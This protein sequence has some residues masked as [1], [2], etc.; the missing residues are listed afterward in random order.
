VALDGETRRL[1]APLQYALRHEALT[2]VV[3]QG[4]AA[5]TS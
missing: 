5:A 2:V 3:P 4:E 1:V